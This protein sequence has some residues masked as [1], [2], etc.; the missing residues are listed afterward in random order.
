MK[1]ILLSLSL[2]FT[3]LSVVATDFDLVH[4]PNSQV[5]CSTDNRLVIV[6]KERRNGEESLSDTL[7]WGRRPSSVG[8]RIE[9]QQLYGSCAVLG[10][11]RS[12]CFVESGSLGGHFSFQYEYG[13][14]FLKGS[15]IDTSGVELVPCPRS[16]LS[17]AVY[18]LI[19][20]YNLY[21]VAMNY[22]SGVRAFLTSIPS[23]P[24]NVRIFLRFGNNPLVEARQERR[25]STVSWF[26][27]ALTNGFGSLYHTSEGELY[28]PW[29]SY[30]T[31]MPW[32]LKRPNGQVIRLRHPWLQLHHRWSDADNQELRTFGVNLLR[33]AVPSP[34]DEEFKQTLQFRHFT[35]QAPSVGSVGLSTRDVTN[36]DVDLGRIRDTY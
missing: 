1:S 32:T 31:M 30:L 25:T 16:I 4:W 21:W 15:S 5:L 20:D 23:D 12:S 34:F 6:Q 13:K 26:R 28:V 35:F 17:N 10:K 36:S 11:H 19:P 14:F 29:G 18:N 33:V 27:H 22:F 24:Y 3:Y 8:Q 7:F 2:L 9:L